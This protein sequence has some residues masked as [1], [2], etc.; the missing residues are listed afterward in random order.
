M[1]CP[2]CQFENREDAKFCK[3]CG[4]KLERLCPSCSHPYQVDSLFCDECGCDIGSAKETSSAISETESPPHQPAV[5]IK[6]NDVA[7]IDGERKYVTV[8]FSDL[9]GYTAM[10]EKLDPEE[11]KEITSRIFGEV[12][13]IV[14]N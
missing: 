10:S 12:S 13:K 5:D 9:S 7:P 3:K 1:Q 2:Q 4:N 11:I 8:L 14:A 6:P